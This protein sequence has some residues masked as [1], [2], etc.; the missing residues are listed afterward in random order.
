[1]VVDYKTNVPDNLSNPAE[2]NI[3]YVPVE[4]KLT[5]EGG[6]TMQAI[7]VSILPR[8]DKDSSE[9][10]N[11]F[12]VKLSDVKFAL[13]GKN[14]VENTIRPRLGKKN[15][16]FV[17]IIGDDELLEK[18]RGIEEIIESMNNQQQVGWLQQFKVACMLSPQLDENNNIVQVSGVEAF[19]HFCTIGWKVL[20]AIVP[21]PRLL[22][23]WAGFLF[24]L[25]FI[26]LITAV[27]IE[28][29]KL[30]G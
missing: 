20:F 26:G 16:C 29:A 14:K 2:P 12:S 27:V 18:A 1:M 15:E 23:G 22:R 19:L 6:E 21:P 17:E 9:R 28:M 13:E 24:S 7:N 5:F 30:F 4:G 3:D 25:I 8:E 10:D 11:V